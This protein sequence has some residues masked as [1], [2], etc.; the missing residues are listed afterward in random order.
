MRSNSGWNLNNHLIHLIICIA[1]ISSRAL[2]ATKEEW[3]QRTIYQALT[4]RIWRNDG[5]TQPCPNLSN[6]CGG[7]WSGIKDQLDYIQGMGFDA[8]WISPIVENIDNGYHGYWLKNL[9]QINPN[10]GS[11]S[12]LVALITEM[13][14]RGMWIMLDVVGNHVGPVQFDYSQIYP[15]NDAA[16]YHDY[17]IINGG[18]FQ[19]NQW[20]VEHCR[21]ADLPDLNQDNQWVSQTLIKW[22]SDT[23]KKYN[24]DGLRIDTIPEVSSDFWQQ[25]AASSG[26]Y[27]VGECFDGRINYV[28]G[29]QGAVDGLLNYPLYY[30]INDVFAYGNSA[31]DLRDALSAISQGFKDITVLGNFVDNHDNPRFLHF[32]GS[33]NRLKNALNFMLFQQGIPIVYYGTEQGYAG[34]ADPANREQLWTNMDS[35]SELYLFLQKSISIRKAFQIWN[36]DLTERYVTD[37]LYAFSRGKVL[38]V[39]TNSNSPKITYELNFLPYNAGDVVC[40]IYWTDDCLTVTSSGLEVDLLGGETK[41]YIPK[42]QII[43]LKQT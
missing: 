15:F 10:F 5:S 14:R 16:H 34:G 20:R 18:D 21:L 32:N 12:D 13:H 35:S 30:A 4:D 19:N 38:I 2:Q 23:V 25:F 43:L 8:I 24:I 37:D 33:H 36:L 31:Y 7:T 26:V 29:Y 6:Y 39:T 11:E 9:Y 1:L 22:I 17:C 41:I 42:S 27:T 3:K 40:D 28:S